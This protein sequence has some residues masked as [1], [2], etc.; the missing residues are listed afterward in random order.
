MYSR[1]VVNAVYGQ[2]YSLFQIFRYTRV[3]HGSASAAVRK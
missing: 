2:R 1:T 3:E